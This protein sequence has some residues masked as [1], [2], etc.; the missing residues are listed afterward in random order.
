MKVYLFSDY[1]KTIHGEPLK[2]DQLICE[3]KTVES[4]PEGL[5]RVKGKLARPCLL[6]EGSIYIEFMEC[7][8]K[9]DNIHCSDNITCPNCG[10]ENRD[11]W[12]A[13]DSD[14]A[15]HC[16]TC[17]SVFRYERNVEVTYSSSIIEI[18]DSVLTLS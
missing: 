13:S 15:H 14:D 16:G 3:I 12:E 1:L 9:K 8:P 5:I 10:S 4:L 2:E 18:S 11:S 17:G 7:I 6:S